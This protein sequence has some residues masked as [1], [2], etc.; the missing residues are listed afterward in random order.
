MDSVTRNPFCMNILGNCNLVLYH[1]LESDVRIL[2]TDTD[3]MDPNFEPIYAI[4]GT[5]IGSTVQSDDI[6]EEDLNY[7]DVVADTVIGVLGFKKFGRDPNTRIENIVKA[8][9]QSLIR[10]A[11][12]PTQIL[13]N[14]SMYKSFVAFIY[15]KILSNSDIVRLDVSMR[16]LTLRIGRIKDPILSNMIDMF[17]QYLQDNRLNDALQ[18]RIND[19][20]E[21]TKKFDRLRDLKGHISQNNDNIRDLEEKKVALNYTK[22]ESIRRVGQNVATGFKM[23]WSWMTRKNNNQQKKKKIQVSYKRRKKQWDALTKQIKE[24]KN[25]IGLYKQI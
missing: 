11:I 4:R 12:S 23:F 24:L 8:T 13:E 2:Y 3:S 25:Q 21:L 16:R 1:D 18:Q 7:M 5:A 22:T 19:I 6:L 10:A 17:N 9:Y 14:H 20:D 15:D